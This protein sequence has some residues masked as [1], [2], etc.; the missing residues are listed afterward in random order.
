VFSVVSF[1]YLSIRLKITLSRYASEA[2]LSIDLYVMIRPRGGNFV[3]TDDEFDQM[4][5]TTM[6]L[7][8]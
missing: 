3:Y 5:D 6:L 2:F 1:F 4:D 7:P 8:L